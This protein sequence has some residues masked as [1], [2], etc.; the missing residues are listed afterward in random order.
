[1]ICFTDNDV[2]LKLSAW[3]LLEEAITVLDTTRKEIYVL[4]TA[5]FV[6]GKDKQARFST[7]YGSQAVQR[8]LEFIETVQ[9]ITQGADPEEQALLNAINGIDEGEAFLFGATRDLDLFL[10]ATGDKNSLRALANAPSCAPIYQRMSG[11]VICMEQIMARLIPHVGFEEVR[12]RVVPARDC[13]NSLKSAFGSGLLAEEV[14]VK[15]SLTVR[16]NELHSEV[17]PLLV[18]DNDWITQVSP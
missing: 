13:D 11:R 14:N 6:I 17:G 9:E 10:V 4:R 15:R 2:L 18:P 5:R 12:R 8:T 16:I 7:K 3:N 1:M